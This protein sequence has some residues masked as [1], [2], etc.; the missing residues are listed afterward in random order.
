MN[1]NELQVSYKKWAES[2]GVKRPP[3]LQKKRITL[4]MRDVLDT[5][6]ILIGQIYYAVPVYTNKL[7]IFTYSLQTIWK[8]DWKD[9]TKTVLDEFYSV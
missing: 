2:L 4:F 5:Q 8:K 6:D 7:N 1:R 9:D 3:S